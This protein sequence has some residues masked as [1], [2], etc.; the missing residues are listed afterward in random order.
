MDEVGRMGDHIREDRD[1][2]VDGE[3]GKGEKFGEGEE[4]KL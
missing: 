2:I 3:D 4:V 1:L